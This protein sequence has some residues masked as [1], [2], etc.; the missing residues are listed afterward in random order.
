M[1][2]VISPR[3]ALDYPHLD[4]DL[5]IIWWSN[6]KKWPDAHRDLMYVSATQVNSL[7]GWALYTI[8]YKDA[9]VFPDEMAAQSW[10]AVHQKRRRHPYGC[11]VTTIRELKERCGYTEVPAGGR[12]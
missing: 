6:G 4:D 1:A 3:Q 7:K 11:R 2:R 10:L 5:W 9:A 8:N 12:D